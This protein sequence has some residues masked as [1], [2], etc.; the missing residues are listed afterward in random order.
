MKNILQHKIPNIL[1]G[2]KIRVLD[3]RSPF[4]LR[5]GI[6]LY[7]VMGFL[8]IVELAIPLGN[9]STKKIKTKIHHSKLEVIE[10][11]N[12]VPISEVKLIHFSLIYEDCNARVYS[13]EEEFSYIEVPSNKVCSEISFL[14]KE[15]QVMSIPR[16]KLTHIDVDRD[17]EMLI[18]HA[19]SWCF[20]ED[21][22]A[23]KAKVQKEL[24]L[25]TDVISKSR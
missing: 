4:F 25:F 21:L 10:I 8:Y 11:D 17:F 1:T 24:G 22:E 15:N 19:E 23:V 7:R 9:G 3:N 5:E 20:E 16:R 18:F 13:K 14:N 2:S 6:V 12:L